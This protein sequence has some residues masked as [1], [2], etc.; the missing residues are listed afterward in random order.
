[1]KETLPPKKKKVVRRTA[2]AWPHLNHPVVSRRH[3]LAIVGGEQILVELSDDERGHVAWQRKG[4]VQPGENRVVVVVACV[5]VRL[6]NAV[7][8]WCDDEC[9]NTAMPVNIVENKFSG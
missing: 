2:V 4:E 9:P 7:Q 5:W 6:I 1:M 3:H 8:F